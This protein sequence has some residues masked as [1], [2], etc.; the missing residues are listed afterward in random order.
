MTDTG[1]PRKTGIGAS[2][3]AEGIALHRFS[4]SRL[5]EDERI[6]C[7]PYAVHFIDPDLLGWAASHPSEAKAL[8]DEWEQ[9]MPGWGNAIRARVRYFDDMVKW[10]AGAGLGQL[11]ILGAG[12]D[13]RAYRL[14]GLKN[15]NVYEVDRPETLRVKTGIITKIFGSLPGQVAYVPV[16]LGAGNLKEELFR[17]G[18]SPQKKTL[19]LLEGLVM[20]MP[21]ESVEDLLAFIRLHSLPG[22]GVIFDCIPDF[23][24]S[25]TPEREGSGAI[26]KYTQAMGEPLRFGLLEGEAG[27]FL[28]NQG[29][30]DV[31]VI[32]G[33][34]FRRLYF[35]GKNAAR[36]VSGLMSLVSG[37]VP[38][39]AQTD[40][41]R[42]M[43]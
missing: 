3:M 43:S 6:F 36:P 18:Y 14:C 13:T 28:A 8:A 5:P 22:S 35:T 37:R 38:D 10:E 40:C 17:A 20:Y 32:T 29:F 19:F 15:L 39:P 1:N 31:T 23:V 4:E 12:Y 33:D 30:S 34:D 41:R 25:G 9:K 16:N 27:S 2:K 7:D 21:R 26:R 24:V 42:G 11:V